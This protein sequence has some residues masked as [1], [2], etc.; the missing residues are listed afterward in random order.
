MEA[1]TAAREPQKLTGK[2][3]ATRTRI[4]EHAA[5]LISAK[6]VHATNDEQLRR[7]AVTRDSAPLE[8]ALRAAADHV[9]AFAV[10]P[11]AHV[12]LGA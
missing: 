10:L 5:E 4:L 2:G 6:G 1:T 3:Q 8:D 9:Q 11:A 7:A 12:G